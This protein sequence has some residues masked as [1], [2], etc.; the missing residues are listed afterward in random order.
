MKECDLVSNLDFNKS[1]A[2]ELLFYAFKN[3]VADRGWFIVHSL[4]LKEGESDFL[5]LDKDMGILLV[6]TK[7]GCYHSRDGKIFCAND[8]DTIDPLEQ[9]DRCKRSVGS[10][11]KGLR[12]HNII[13]ENEK[14]EIHRCVW[15][16]DSEPLTDIDE[17]GA[18]WM[19]MPL[20][21]YNPRKS[22]D[23]RRKAVGD[24]KVQFELYDRWR[25]LVTPGGTCLS[26]ESFE[27]LK[28]KFNPH[29]LVGQSANWIR[30][31]KTSVS[32]D[33]C[34][35][36]NA[37]LGMLAHQRK[38]IVEGGAGTGKTVLALE[39]A[40][41][42]AYGGAEGS[43]TYICY[44]DLLRQNLS[45]TFYKERDPDRRVRFVNLFTKYGVDYTNCANPQEEVAKE[46]RALGD[47]C[48]LCNVIIDEAQDFG[49]DVLQALFDASDAAGGAFYVFC[50]LKQCVHKDSPAAWLKDEHPGM[51]RITL[52]RNLRNTR[53]IAVSVAGPVGLPDAYC[54]TSLSG[55][56]PRVWLSAPADRFDL[57]GKIIANYK[58][59]GVDTDT[60]ILTVM[61]IGSLRYKYNEERFIRVGEIKLL[62]DNEDK[63]KVSCF[64]AKDI[65]FTTARKYKGLEANHVI[66]IDLDGHFLDDDELTYTAASRSCMYLDVILSSR[67]MDTGLLEKAVK[68]LNMEPGSL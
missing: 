13:G 4:L 22:N 39:K 6:E 41:R 12:K 56:K 11:L 1:R 17:G 43:V 60:V 55:P 10:Y 67:S 29:R 52:S 8:R 53:E 7:S 61:G 18:V 58:A 32:E 15:M 36:Q 2:E 34:R 46:I 54:N 63:N 19:Y 9:L 31:R 30:K 45:E 3:D 49:Q 16:P 47:R 33:L 44:N 62:P 66:V 38:A 40:Y 26:E 68:K 50:D 28:R 21:D 48:D 20:L 27:T 25:K 37:L 14:V 23:I 35:S 42:L 65:L 57:A 59:E 64:S 51:P 5:I 24:Q